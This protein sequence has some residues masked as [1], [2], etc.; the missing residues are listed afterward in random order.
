M[1]D[2]H[3]LLLYTYAP[4]VLDR[5]PAF[6]GQHLEL[7]RAA[8]AAGDLV[9]GGA[10]ADPVDQGI[11]LFKGPSSAAAEAFAGADPYVKQGLVTAW[12]IREWTTVVGPDAL[13]K[14]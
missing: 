6:R 2:K 1:S 12:R 14:V 8:V 5:R 9:L 10:L 11:L 3:F 13:T 4:D 7:A